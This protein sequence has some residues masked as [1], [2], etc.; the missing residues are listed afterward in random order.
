M[1]HPE[2]GPA[3]PGPSAAWDSDLGWDDVVSNIP[4][5]L[6]KLR[7]VGEG[8]TLNFG[9]NAALQG[10]VS[11]LVTL[12]HQE[13]PTVGKGSTGGHQPHCCPRNFPQGLHLSHQLLGRGHISTAA[14]KLVLQAAEVA[15]NPRKGRWLLSG[16]EALK[17]VKPG[18][19]P[20][21]LCS[22]DVTS[23]EPMNSGS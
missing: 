23:G 3:S 11:V 14:L 6:P 2:P 17:M 16:A 4:K 7:C 15:S 10:S 13:H 12:L 22:G 8:H 20:A 19:K 1:T 5:P 9:D 18:L 21:H